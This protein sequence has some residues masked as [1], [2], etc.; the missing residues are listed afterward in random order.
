MDAFG[1]WAWC[2][3]YGKLYLDV[4]CG[5]QG[6]WVGSVAECCGDVQSGGNVGRA[7]ELVIGV[8]GEGGRV[9]GGE[10]VGQG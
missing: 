2:G 6:V 1:S 5:D 9:V 4:F 7:I 8:D 10:R 3:G